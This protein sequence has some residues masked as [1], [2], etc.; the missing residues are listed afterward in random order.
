VLSV[1][2]LT[3][4]FDVFLILWYR[5]RLGPCLTLNEMPNAANPV[6]KMGHV[7]KGCAGVAAEDSKR[8]MYY[9]KDVG[10]L[11]YR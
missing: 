6:H 3:L 7:H 9:V 10:D 2:V 8:L 11:H 5:I 4:S 1:L